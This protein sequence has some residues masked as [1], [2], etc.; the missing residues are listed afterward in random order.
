MGDEQKKT[1]VEL[2]RL[3]EF[4]KQAPSGDY[5]ID[6]EKQR[7]CHQLG[8][9]QEKCVNLNLEGNVIVSFMASSSMEEEKTKEGSTRSRGQWRIRKC[10]T[11]GG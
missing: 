10:L 5:N 4:V 3:D 2:Q 8:S 6:Q 1:E 11:V 7:I 9:G